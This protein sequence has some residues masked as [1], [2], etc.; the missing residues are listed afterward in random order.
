[1]LEL[2]LLMHSITNAPT[3]LHAQGTIQLV[4]NGEQAT[5]SM[6]VPVPPRQAWAVL[7]NYG[8]TLGA[9]PDVVSVQLVSRRNQ[10][11]RLRQVLQAPYTFG[12]RVQAL[13]EGKED[14]QQLRLSYSLVSGERIRALSGRWTLTPEAGGTR[15]VHSIRLTPEVPTFLQ[16]SFR[17]LHDS[18]LRQSFKTLRQLMLDPSALSKR[19]SRPRAIIATVPSAL[20]NSASDWPE[21]TASALSD[22]SWGLTRRSANS[23]TLRNA[24]KRLLHSQP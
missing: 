2:L 12:L 16:G 13:L 21:T 14:P 23:E 10:T 24:S 9:M 6:Q 20:N 8:K 3:T 17:N 7:T 1:M 15:V 11:V 4:R 22:S 5:L 18:S 19:L